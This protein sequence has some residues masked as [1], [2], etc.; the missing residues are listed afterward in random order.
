LRPSLTR[1]SKSLVPSACARA[2]A[3]TPASQILLCRFAQGLR[4]VAPA[5]ARWRTRGLLAGSLLE[6]GHVPSAGAV[7]RRSEPEHRLAA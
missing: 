3:P 5:L 1:P 2:K 6:L 7:R 4:Q